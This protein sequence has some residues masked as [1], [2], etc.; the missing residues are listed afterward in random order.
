L[1]AGID[2]RLH[3]WRIYPYFVSGRYYCVIGKDLSEAEK[4]DFLFLSGIG[5]MKEYHEILFAGFVV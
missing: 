5:K 4:I 3:V 1:G 2:Q